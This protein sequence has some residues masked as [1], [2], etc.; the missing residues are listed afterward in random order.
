MVAKISSQCDKMQRMWLHN[1]VHWK[2]LGLKKIMVMIK[3]NEDAEKLL[4]WIIKQVWFNDDIF[5]DIF[6]SR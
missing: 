6:P 1:L 3:I 4:I 5:W 2:V